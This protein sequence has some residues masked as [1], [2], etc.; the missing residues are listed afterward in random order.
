MARYTTVHSQLR[1]K[2]GPASAYPCAFCGG[3]AQDWSYDRL[4]PNEKIEYR[5]NRSGTVA[6]PYS[7]DFDRYQPVCRGCHVY[8]DRGFANWATCLVCTSKTMHSYCARHWVGPRRLAGIQLGHRQAPADEHG[9]KRSPR[10]RLAVAS[11]MTHKRCNQCE[12]TLPVAAFSVIRSR[13]DNPNRD[14]YRSYCLPCE[15]EKGIARYLAR[16]GR[17]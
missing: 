9:R 6:C 16:T 1:K 17:A 2:F 13:A 11:T 5:K 3:Q 10:H 12:E 15:Q 8:R 7:E 14:P 4:C